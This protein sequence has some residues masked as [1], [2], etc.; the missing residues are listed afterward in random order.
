MADTER[1]N[2]G[3]DFHGFL[4]IG[5][6]PELLVAFQRIVRAKIDPDKT[7]K[8]LL[9]QD[10]VFVRSFADRALA[11][12]ASKDSAQDQDEAA[13]PIARPSAHV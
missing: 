13:R 9:D 2:P 6:D 12:A 3:D 5:N 7:E 11:V 8:N 1:I 10:I 4:A